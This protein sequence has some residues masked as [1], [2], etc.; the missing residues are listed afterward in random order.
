MIWT[1][2]FPIVPWQLM[3]LFFCQGVRSEAEQRAHCPGALLEHRRI[4]ICIPKKIRIIFDYLY[5][6]ERFLIFNHF[7][8]W[9]FL[10][11]FFDDAKVADS[12]LFFVGA[13]MKAEQEMSQLSN[14]F[15]TV[16]D[17][18]E[19]WWWWWCTIIAEKAPM[20][21]QLFDFFLLLGTLTV[22]HSL[23]VVFSRGLQMNHHKRFQW[24][25]DL[26]I[27][28][29]SNIQ[30]GLLTS[31]RCWG[32]ISVSFNGVDGLT[33]CTVADTH[34]YRRAEGAIQVARREATGTGGRID[35]CHEEWSIGRRMS[36]S[37][38]EILSN[39]IKPKQSKKRCRFSLI[40]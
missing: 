32:K 23:L 39:R 40:L 26:Y 16:G 25:P 12:A 18:Q 20:T 8:G 30:H 38:P 36:W 1:C 17:T 37:F 6:K 35:G 11:T 3:E 4:A 7:F 5:L 24:Q 13:G 27:L 29:A 9:S 21:L 33:R 34:W 2:Y 15:A 31:C 14:R 19:W 28:L 22:D 10:K